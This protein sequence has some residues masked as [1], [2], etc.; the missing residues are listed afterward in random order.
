MSLPLRT[1]QPKHRSREPT[2]ERTVTVAPERL[3]R[4]LTGFEERHGKI[5]VSPEG[6]QVV[7][8]ATDGARAVLTVPFPPLPVG[9][10]TLDDLVRHVEVERQVG[11]L[12][13]RKG[14]YAAGVF[15]GRQ[16]IR[17]KVGSSY[18]QGRTKAG[19]WSQQRFA[20]RREKQAGKA[21]QSA[22]D[23]AVSVLLPAVDDLE[24]IVLGGDR[25]GVEAVLADSRLPAVRAKCGP[26]LLPV[27][28]PRLSVLRAFPDQ[29]LAVRIHL[30]DLA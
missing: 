3:A 20:R 23:A 16:L 2:A 15:A 7:I 25:T 6:G 12:L 30:N 8:A 4:W 27:A 22:A 19:G 13:V 28:E 18:V 14:G 5:T 24:T 17:S 1:V 29:F 11:A 21:Y 26:R 10:Q 9:V